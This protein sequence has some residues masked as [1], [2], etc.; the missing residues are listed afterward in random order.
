MTLHDGQITVDCDITESKEATTDLRFVKIISDET[1]DLP[2]NRPKGQ[3]IDVTFSYNANQVMQCS[4][5]DVETGAKKDIELTLSNNTSDSNT[6][7]DLEEF[8]VE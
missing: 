1:L 5:V 7:E 2:P 8:L 6:I 4:F 3:K